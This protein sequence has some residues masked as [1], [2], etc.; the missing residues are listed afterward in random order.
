M[1]GQKIY[2]IACSLLFE[3]PGMD[4]FF[5]NSAVNLINVLVA[6]AVPYQNNRNRAQNKPEIQVFDILTLEDDVPLDDPITAIAL[7]Y[8]L[9]AYFY[10]DEE[11]NFRAQ[12]FR[13]RFIAAL[14]DAK[15][16][17]LVDITDEYGEGE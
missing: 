10:Q 14:E 2:E 9:A 6:E 7:P 8:G 12:D 4:K 1:T 13:G 3:K 17:E 16:C 11:D 5:Y 15:L